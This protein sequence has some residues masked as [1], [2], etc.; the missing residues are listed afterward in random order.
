MPILHNNGIFEQVKKDILDWCGLSL[1]P[2]TKPSYSAFAA[3]EHEVLLVTENSD[4]MLLKEHLR[5]Y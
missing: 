1:P 4:V 2:G 5:S 3:F